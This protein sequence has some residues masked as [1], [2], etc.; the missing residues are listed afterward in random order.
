MKSFSVLALLV[1]SCAAKDS[2]IN[3]Q[4]GNSS[5]VGFSNKTDST[6]VAQMTITNNTDGDFI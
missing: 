3:A 5:V 4:V 1:A 2:L 6:Y